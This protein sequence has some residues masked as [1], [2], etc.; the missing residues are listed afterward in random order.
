MLLNAFRTFLRIKDGPKSQFSEQ[1]ATWDDAG[2]EGW[3]V[4][5]KTHSYNIIM[6]RT[7]LPDLGIHSAEII[8]SYALR[9]DT[10]TQIYA[11][12][13]QNEL[14][15]PQQK[16]RPKCNNITCHYTNLTQP[17]SNSNYYYM[18]KKVNKPQFHSS[19]QLDATIY[20]WMLC[21]TF[22]CYGTLLYAMKCYQMLSD[23]I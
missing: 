6:Q 5:S 16:L 17:F 23:A 22:G 14:C 9:C 20:Y 18:A 21:Y 15:M 3:K 7:F 10:P 12:S 2:L 19:N 13:A 4:E 8:L 11:H 1:C